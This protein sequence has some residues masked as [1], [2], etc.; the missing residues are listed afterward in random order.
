MDKVSEIKD[1][2][3]ENHPDKAWPDECECGAGMPRPEKAE[4]IEWDYSQKGS[5]A[6][7]LSGAGDALRFRGWASCDNPDRD[8]QTGIVAGRYMPG[9]RD[10]H[11]GVRFEDG[12]EIGFPP[13]YVRVG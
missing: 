11:I 3:C 4:Q 12:E 2:V 7:I 6:L 1:W 5:A 8:G 13:Q 9:G 10:D